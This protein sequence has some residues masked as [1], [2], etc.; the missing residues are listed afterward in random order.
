MRIFLD[1]FNRNEKVAD[2][3][4]YQLLGISSETLQKQL[5][6]ALSFQ[7]LHLSID[8]DACKC[9]IIKYIHNT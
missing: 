3:R 4:N 1:A 6:F 2:A 8:K 7:K 5:Y 9:T